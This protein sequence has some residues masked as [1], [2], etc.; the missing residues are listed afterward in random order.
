[1]DESTT[2]KLMTF[3]EQMLVHSNIQDNLPTRCKGVVDL[4]SCEQTQANNTETRK[5]RSLDT[6]QLTARTHSNNR[7]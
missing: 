2:N 5:V 7:T 1:M 3:S 4:I 6:T